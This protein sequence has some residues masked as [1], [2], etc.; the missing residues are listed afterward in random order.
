MI[1]GE[2]LRRR[3]PVLI[4]D[5]MKKYPTYRSNPSTLLELRPGTTGDGIARAG[6][7]N[8]GNISLSGLIN[9]PWFLDF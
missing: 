7:H 9:V 4:I 1:S 8:Y 2:T 3:L 6:G 5:G